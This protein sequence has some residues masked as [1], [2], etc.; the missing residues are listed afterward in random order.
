MIVLEYLRCYH[1]SQQPNFQKMDW[2]DAE[3]KQINFLMTLVCFFGITSNLYSQD[4]PDETALKKLI[5]KGTEAWNNHDADALALLV[6]DTVTVS[7]THL[8]LPTKA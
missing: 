5:N 1:E 2:S 4:N 8:T 6:D 7:Y 3:M